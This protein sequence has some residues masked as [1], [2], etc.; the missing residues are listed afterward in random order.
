[1]SWAQKLVWLL[2]LS[3]PPRSGS[4]MDAVKDSSLV[5]GFEKLCISRV[6]DKDMC[7]H[8]FLCWWCAASFFCAQHMLLHAHGKL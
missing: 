2:E 3:E 6:E 4:S 7:F 5:R 8:C 1:M